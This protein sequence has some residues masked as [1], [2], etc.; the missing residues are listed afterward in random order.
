MRRHLR[1]VHKMS[2]TGNGKP[3]N[4]EKINQVHSE[5]ESPS[6]TAENIIK[7]RPTSST[8]AYIRHE[9]LPKNKKQFDWPVSKST[10]PSAKP[11]TFT[12]KPIKTLSMRRKCTTS[13]PTPTATMASPVRSPSP[14]EDLQDLQWLVH[15]LEDPPSNLQTPVLNATPKQDWITLD[16]IGDV[17]DLPPVQTF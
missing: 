16:S 11:K 12:T 15:A 5:G 1:T 6:K 8:T 10:S 13:P 17:D 14:P 9:T 3:R 2:R 4:S 7:V